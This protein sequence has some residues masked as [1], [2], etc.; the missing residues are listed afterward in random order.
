MIKN[1]ALVSVII[2]TKNE[3]AHIEDCLRS[4]KKQSYKNIEIIVVDNNSSDKTKKISLKY[5]KK[6]F[7]K[8]P[9]RSV[10][11]N[12]GVEKAKGEYILYLD[13]DMILTREVVQ[14]GVKTSVYNHEIKGLYIP[15]KIVG[16]GF[17]I[18]A[19]AFER[20]FYDATA[21][22]C[23]RFIRRDAFM[24]VE[25]FNENLTGP[26]DWD[27][28]KK[29]RNIGKTALMENI[30]YHN[31]GQFNMS[32]YLSKKGYYAK[33]FDKYMDKWGK[34]DKDIKKQFGVY[35]R[36]LGV[37]IENGKWKNFIKHPLLAIGMYTLR[38]LVGLKFL[39]RDK[40]EI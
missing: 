2:T 32:K 1:K 18:K 9:E 22:D 24:R 13:A 28:D 16:D 30:L 5:T 15:E 37:F 31:E 39:A 4:I 10:Q 7:N 33:S 6:F 3:E 25:G 14:E 34:N 38:V 26:E 35:Y 21:I 27:F 36:F 11:R 40:N 17:W 29:I 8:G 20:S 23:V 12:F 19:R